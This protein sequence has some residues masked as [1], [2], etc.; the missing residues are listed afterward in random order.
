MAGVLVSA[1]SPPADL[2]AWLANAGLAVVDHVLG[3]V[4]PV[5]FEPISAAVI[6]VGDR[7][8][9]AAIQTR[10]W[11]AELGDDLVPIVWILPAPDGRLA[12]RGLDSGADAVLACPLQAELLVA[13]IRG[14]ARARTVARRLIARAS[15]SQILG[16]RL[17]KTLAENDRER[18]A[19]R[20]LRFAFLQRS[21]PDAG[22]VRFAV[23]HR[24]R[25]AVGGDFYEVLPIDR[26]RIVFLV[27]DV[28]GPG[29][30]GE[31]VGHFATRIAT[32]SA[33]RAGVPESA[34]DVLAEVNRELLRLGLEDPPLVALTLGILDPT[35]GALS[36]ARAGIP[37]PVHVPATGE[38]QE[39]P[40]PGPFLCTA[41][42]GYASRAAC[43]RPGDKLLIGTDGIVRDGNVSADDGKNRLL[44][45][46]ARHRQLCGQAFVDA[47]A[48]E[49]LVDIAHED[50]IT[51]LA[52]EMAHW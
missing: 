25:S 51:I 13:Q 18:T 7:P 27:G 11:R 45:A 38:P 31:F 36:L 24:S 23:N 40:I 15:E 20:R 43:L 4:P 10:R 47:V 37:A 48:H 32:R 8:D 9:A 21:F 1:A 35:T 2:R 29:A 22:P 50:D 6:E 16:E 19:A 42:T 39:W 41:E 44:T 5:D 26:D 12:T 52:V 49:L 17:Q 30:A 3:S 34:G 14:A 33:Q 28:V 46:A